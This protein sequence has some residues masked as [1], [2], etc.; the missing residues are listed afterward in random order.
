MQ[1]PPPPLAHPGPAVPPPPP[2]PRGNPLGWLLL[3]PAVIAL[4]IGYVIPTLRTFWSSLHERNPLTESSQWVGLDN[5]ERVMTAEGFSSVGFALSLVL[6]VLL[7]LLLVAPLLSLAASHSGRPARLV[8]RLA[9]AVPMVCFVPVGIAIGWRLDRLTTGPVTAG[10]AAGDVRAAVWL[11]MFGLICGL[12]VTFYL[13]AFRRDPRGRGW[14]W[15]SAAVVAGLALVAALAVGLQAYTYPLTITGGGPGDATAT[16][17]LDAFRR[18][19]QLFDF[20]AGNAVAALLLLA[21]MA[22]GIGAALLVI[23]TGMRIEVAPAPGQPGQPDQPGRWDGIRVLA[24]VGTALLLAGVL[25]VTVYG[26]WPW[27]TRLGVGEIDRSIPG[28]LARTWLPPVV[29]TVVGVGLAAVAGFGIGALRPLGRAS[30]MLL[31]PFAPWLFIGVG[32]LFLTKYESAAFGTFE[33][34]NSVPGVIPPVWLVV[35]ALFLFTL[36]FRGLVRQDTA[37][38]PYGRVL[39]RSLPMVGL[40]AGATWLVQSQSL[41]WGLMA[42]PDPDHWPAPAWA[43]NQ[44]RQFPLAG[45]ELGLGLVL[46]VPLL[47]VL[48]IALALVHVLYLERLAIRVGRSG[49]AGH[50]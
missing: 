23:L 18:G 29:S 32:P 38:R 14:P 24:V 13:A 10:D 28:I 2:V 27:L 39:V 22:L 7:V 4:V 48:A 6:L 40:V 49:Y 34:I 30:E 26:L 5:Y 47:V 21:V 44:D 41:L 15:A 31:L 50:G 37:P 46:P 45:D 20:G 11:G 1:P 3:V 19:V 33:R 9:L 42:S 35:P 36:L 17:M 25:A 8:V 12:G 16:P 43:I